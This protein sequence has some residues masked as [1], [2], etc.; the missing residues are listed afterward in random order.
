LEKSI[1]FVT[2]NHVGP[3]HEQALFSF[4]SGNGF[5]VKDGW[6]KE[7]KRW[8]FERVRSFFVG[9]ST[10]IL[11]YYRPTSPYFKT[12]WV[13]VMRPTRALLGLL[14]DFFDGIGVTP[15]IRKLELSF[16]FHTADP[17][18][19][20]EFLMSHLYLWH[21]RSKSKI[22]KDTYYTNDLRGAANGMR[23]Y[24]KREKGNVFYSRM[25]LHLAKG[26]VR[27]LG[28]KWLLNDLETFKLDKHFSF[29]E[30]DVD[31]VERMWA[32]R[33]TPV[34]RPPTTHREKLASK[35]LRRAVESWLRTEPPKHLGLMKQIEFLKDRTIGLNKYERYLRL[36]PFDAV[37][38]AAV[39]KL[40]FLP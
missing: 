8:K 21:Q 17:G 7:Y 18:E 10:Q 28:L 22:C 2:L 1:D 27:Q 36:L 25:E 39:S 37:F 38:F 33:P 9:G 3:E 24:L 13:Q 35:M 14:D 16:D 5:R 40:K 20:H 23:C 15:R 11:V 34:T 30:V 29:I 19:M 31:H 6:N 4:L 26:P 12:L 32:G